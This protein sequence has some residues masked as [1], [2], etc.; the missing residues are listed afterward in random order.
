MPVINLTLSYQPAFIDAAK[1]LNGVGLNDREFLVR[2]SH[3]SKWLCIITERIHLDRE[4][5]DSHGPSTGALPI[6]EKIT[7]TCHRYP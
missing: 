1:N 3:V 4:T 5:F 7:T 2:L 6:L